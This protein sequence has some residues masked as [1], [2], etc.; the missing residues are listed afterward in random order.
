MATS[1]LQRRRN[2]NVGDCRR[3]L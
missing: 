3:Q 2:S 1:H